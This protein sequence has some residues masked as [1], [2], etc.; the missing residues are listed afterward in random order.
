[1]CLFVFL[2]FLL[3]VFSSVPTFVLI[4]ALFVFLFFST[5]VLIFALFVLL[6][7][8]TFVLIFALFVFL[9]VPS[10]GFP[11][12]APRG[13]VFNPLPFYLPERGEARK[14]LGGETAQEK[15]SMVDLCQLV[16]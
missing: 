1:M 11:V 7:V 9:S 8:S 13:F 10:V 3:Y 6:S 14:K 5:L 2:S 12:Y 16:H 15:C 4:F